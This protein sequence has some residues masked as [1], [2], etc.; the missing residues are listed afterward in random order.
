MKAFL[1]FAEVNSWKAID[2]GLIKTFFSFGIYKYE[3]KTKLTG[4][5]SSRQ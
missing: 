3:V 1:I 4:K 2:L 5:P